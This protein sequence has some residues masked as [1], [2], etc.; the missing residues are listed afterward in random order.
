[1]TLSE[2]IELTKSGDPIP[3]DFND[4]PEIPE[5]VTIGRLDL[6]RL[7]EDLYL[8]PI[9]FFTYLRDRT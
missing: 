9:P 4:W 1:M 8:R 3:V 6:N 5:N 7:I 2:R